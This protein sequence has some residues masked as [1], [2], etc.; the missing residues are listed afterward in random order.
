[1]MEQMTLAIA[2]HKYLSIPGETL[3]NFTDQY[4]MLTEK[5]KEDLRR[6]F[7]KVGVVIIKKV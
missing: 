4:K 2:C 5:D 7:S 6:E 1:M 3:K